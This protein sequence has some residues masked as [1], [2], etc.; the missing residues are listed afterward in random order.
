MTV[1]ECLRCMPAGVFYLIMYIK[2]PMT[3]REIKL[4][5]D[6]AWLNA[7]NYQDFLLEFKSGIFNIL[8][9][10]TGNIRNEIYIAEEFDGYVKS[11]WRMNM[12]QS[13]NG[14]YVFTLKDVLLV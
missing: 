13:R 14:Y 6:D 7:V 11:R 5:L 3:I 10:K 4:S 1:P 12:Q 2:I 9:F 8:L